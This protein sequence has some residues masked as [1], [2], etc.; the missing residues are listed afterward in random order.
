MKTKLMMLCCTLM[1]SLAWGQPPSTTTLSGTVID[2]RTGEPLPA[3]TVSLKEIGRSTQTNVDGRFVFADVSKRVLTLRF[4]CIGYHP[5]DFTL[6]SDEPTT[7]IVIRM[8][9]DAGALD[10]VVVTGEVREPFRVNQQIG[11]I[12]MNPRLIASLPSLGEKDIF[13]AFQLMP[14]VSAANEQSAGLYVRGGTPD[15]NLVLFDGFTVYNVDHLF[16]FFSAFNANAIKDV[17]LFKGGF[18]AKYGGRL[19]ALMDITGKEGN[20]HTF[21]A[22]VDIGLLSVNAFIETPIGDR[23]SS[24]IT[25]RRSFGTSFYNKLKDQATVDNRRT[26]RRDSDRLTDIAERLRGRADVESYFDDLNAKLTYYTEQG[27]VFSWSVYHGKDHL[28][29]SI[30]AGDGWFSRRFSSLLAN[31]TDVASWGNTGTSLKWSRQWGSSLY[32]HTLVSYANYFSK[33]TNTLHTQITDS[34]GTVRDFQSG[35]IEDNKLRDYAVRTDWEWVMSATQRLGFGAQHSYQDMAYRYAR[36]DTETLIDRSGTGHTF[37]VY[38]EDMLSLAGHRLSVLPGVRLTH[39]TPTA[40][41]YAEPRMRADYRVSETVS[42]KTSAGIYHQFAKRV[43]REDVLRGS[44]DFWLLADDN[45][46][47]V[48]RSRQLSAGLSWENGQFL[49]DAEGYVKEMAGLSEYTL[50]FQSASGAADYADFFYKGS[51][52]ATGIDLLVQKK[53]GRYTGWVG[54]TLARVI[55]RFDIYGPDD[56]PAANDVRNEFKMV[57]NYRMGRFD[58]SMTWM[59]M[60]GKPYTAPT[61]GYELTLLDGTKQMYLNVSEKNALRLPDYHRLDMA[62]TLYFGRPAQFNGALCLSLFNV[63]SRQNVWYKNFNIVDNEIIET[64][65]NYLGFTPNLSLSVKLN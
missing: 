34:L 29:N 49:I 41:W 20:K 26:P 3:V 14:G 17:Q 21:N 65:V 1:V 39:F 11:M 50:R 31:T 56:F 43:I 7:G 47:P 61:G 4:T 44:R 13:R 37:S 57:H 36:N 42:L 15:Q 10:E 55:N 51:G 27:D 32:S 18:D 5:H 58:F 63:Y 2:D 40:G 22:G 54:Y 53:A 59:Y 46:L 48:S 33:R 24:L 23:I 16:G 60:T 64:D 35:T 9:A 8:L 6:E 19:S 52:T 30:H 12:R 45:R 38:A 28:D 62:V 25:Y